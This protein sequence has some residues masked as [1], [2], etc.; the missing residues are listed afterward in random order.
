MLNPGLLGFLLGGD[1]L[2]VL[3]RAIVVVLSVTDANGET[4][5]D[6]RLGKIRAFLRVINKLLC[7]NSS[8]KMVVRFCQN[9]A[10][11]GVLI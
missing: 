5:G 9:M 4:A 7:T 3:R 2:I 8:P 1:K 11:R 10:Y 6:Q